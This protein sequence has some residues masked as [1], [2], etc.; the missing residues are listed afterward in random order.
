MS[1]AFT[2]KMAYMANLLSGPELYMKTSL[3]SVYKVLCGTGSQ[4]RSIDMCIV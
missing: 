4:D 1:E 2:Q 3:L